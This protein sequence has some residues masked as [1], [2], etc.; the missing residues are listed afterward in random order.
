M[1]V[2]NT[3]ATGAARAT[4]KLSGHRW[5]I[6]GAAF[7]V[8][9]TLGFWGW[10]IQDCVLPR[11][12]ALIPLSGPRVLTCTAHAHPSAGIFDAIF[13]ALQLLTLQFPQSLSV[14]FPWQ[15]QV[16]RFL[17]PVTALVFGFNILLGSLTRPLRLALLPAQRGHIVVF[18]ETALTDGAFDA[19][20]AKNRTVVLLTAAADDASREALE[21]R[22]ITVVTSDPHVPFDLSIANIRQAGAL[23]LTHAHDVDN[24][25]LAGRAFEALVDR[26]KDMPPLALGVRIADDRLADQLAET[27]DRLPQRNAAR[28]HRIAPDRDTLAQELVRHAPILTRTDRARPAEV[29][30]YGL[31]ERFSSSLFTLIGAL[32]DHPDH[33]PIVAIKVD[34]GERA[35]LAAWLDE[36]PDLHLVV[37][38]RIA[39]TPHLV[40][41][42]EADRADL[43]IVLRPEGEGLAAA[44]A[45]ART[46]DPDRTRRI[47]LWRHPAGGALAAA[48]GGERLVSFGGVVRTDFVLG[49]LDGRSDGVAAALHRHYRRQAGATAT[50]AGALDWHALPDMFRSANRAAAEHAPIMLASAGYRLRRLEAARGPAAAVSALVI[51]PDASIE[52]LA[53]I[54]HRRWMTERISAGWRSATAR[55]NDRRLHTAIV[56]YEALSE[57]DREK[58]RAAVRGLF[59]ALHEAGFTVEA[60][61]ADTPSKPD[62]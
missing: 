31:S 44:M 57:A 20:V 56:P 36:H 15:L 26:P 40:A 13:K 55:D 21:G 11:W 4:K 3:V 17:V 35:R 7:L 48:I 47:V 60:V 53:R 42:T 38:L 62:A 43:A 28:L 8:A 12:L 32:Q 41:A 54:E 14:V 19:L 39:L 10:L 46:S 52:A 49:I 30:V 59:A 33:R 50:S 16:A 51:P 1:P 5:W 37:D 45:L 24:A 9:F 2:L 61:A 25:A 58:D 29:S 34:E 27:F 18:G 6:Q 22:G 23:L